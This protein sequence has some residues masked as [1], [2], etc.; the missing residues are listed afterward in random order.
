MSVLIR[1]MDMPGDCIKC[2]LCLFADGYWKCLADRSHADFGGT[3]R[4]QNC[5][6]VEAPTPHGRLAV[7]Y[8]RLCTLLNQ[9]PTVIEAEDRK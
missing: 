3:C 1:E 5:P 4:P 2:P 9:A 6:L 8:Q 7:A